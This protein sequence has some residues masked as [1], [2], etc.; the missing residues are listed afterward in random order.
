MSKNIIICCDGT[1]NLY[2]KKKTNVAKLFD[3][4]DSNPEKQLNYY[5]LGVGTLGSYLSKTKIGKK[6]TRILGLAIAFG[7]T[8]NIEEAYLFLMRNY[9]QGDKIYLFGFS[10]GAYT[11]RA[12]GGML[13]R[14]GLLYPRHENL[15]SYATK[16][17]Y[18][19]EILPDET[20]DFKT[21]FSREVLPYFIGVWDTVKSVGTKN[22]VI[23]H[24]N[25]LNKNVPFGYHALAIDERRN[26]FKPEL[27]A[28]QVENQ[29]IVQT[30]FAGV[31]SDIG[32]SYDEAGLSNITLHWM[33]DN[34][35]K[36]GLLINESQMTKKESELKE[37]ISTKTHK[38]LKLL[39]RIFGWGTRKIKKDAIIHK[40]VY[41]KIGIGKGYNPK[42]VRKR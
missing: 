2:C 25:I 31:H 37:D 19:K 29:T 5:D 42:N 6:I 13:S 40:T 33:I 22:Q 24:D 1:G 3:L 8:E 18:D 9:Q 26:K 10:R 16:I 7:I 28:N 4:L 21:T 35:K 34:A 39:W 23:F 41:D 15:I 27:W 36:H 38:S 14:C 20:K 32:G 17:Y 12:L 30:W 11:V